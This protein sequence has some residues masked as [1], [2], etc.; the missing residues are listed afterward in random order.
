MKP[1][2]YIEATIIGHLTSRIPKDVIVA[3]EMMMTRA[4][5]KESR[6]RFDVLVRSWCGWRLRAE[7]RLLLRNVWKGLLMLR[8]C[9]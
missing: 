3:G 5:W 2:V 4:W 6:E 9:L 8:L 1:T 7:M